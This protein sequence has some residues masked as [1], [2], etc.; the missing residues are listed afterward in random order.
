M[1]RKKRNRIFKNE[2]S[3]KECYGYMMAVPEGEEREDKKY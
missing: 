1:Q 2:G 3:H